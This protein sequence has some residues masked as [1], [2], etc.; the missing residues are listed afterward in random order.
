M[1]S[2][3][4][5]LYISF[6][7]TVGMLATYHTLTAITNIIGGIIDNINHNQMV[8]RANK[9]LAEFDELQKQADK[10]DN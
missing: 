3:T 4:T 7:F 2:I 5:I 10:F 1:L 9:T 6:W 8:D